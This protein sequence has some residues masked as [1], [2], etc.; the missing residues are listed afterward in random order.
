MTEFHTKSLIALKTDIK[1]AI[2][3]KDLRI[4]MQHNKISR[5]W[6]GISNWAFSLCLLYDLGNFGLANVLSLYLQVYTPI[7]A[8]VDFFYLL[9]QLREV[10]LLFHY[11]LS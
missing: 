7:A 6:N 9:V 1:N 3:Y 4:H 11:G 10:Y 8:I 5:I 2:P